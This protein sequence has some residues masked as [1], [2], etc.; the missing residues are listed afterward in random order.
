MGGNGVGH[1]RVWGGGGL[2]NSGGCEVECGLELGDWCV[3]CGM[4]GV[5]CGVRGVG[6]CGV[7]GAGFGVRGV[8]CGVCCVGSLDCSSV[9]VI[10]SICLSVYRF[11]FCLVVKL[12]SDSGAR[13]P[14]AQSAAQIEWRLG[15]GWHG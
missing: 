7:W 2:G 10:S 12:S 11:Y 4:S 15:M 5:G 9:F 14:R 8:G 1:G 6:L 3:G 13:N